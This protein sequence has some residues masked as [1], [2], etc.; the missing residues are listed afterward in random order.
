MTAGVVSQTGDGGV[1]QTVLSSSL[2]TVASTAA[3]QT[4]S[5]STA[6]GSGG[7][8]GGGAITQVGALK[9]ANFN[10]TA[11]QAI[12][13]TGPAGNW[14]IDSIIIANPSGSIT[15]AKGGFYTAA[16]KT[17]QLLSNGGTTFPYAA[18]TGATVAGGVILLNATLASNLAGVTQYFT[19]ASQTIF[20]SLTTPQGSAL[21]ADIYVFGRQLT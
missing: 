2:S 9:S 13:L 1:T 4:T 5:L 14:I 8:G 17:G 7:S 15:T 20:L 3:S 6:V 21:T 16:S 10:S 18:I 12:A 19:S 11:D